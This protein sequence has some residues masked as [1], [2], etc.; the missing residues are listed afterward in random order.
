MYEIFS[1]YDTILHVVVNEER[2][3]I[4]FSLPFFINQNW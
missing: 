4:L 3:F 1:W 2:I